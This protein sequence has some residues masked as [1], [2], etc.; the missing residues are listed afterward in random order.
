MD[1]TD[2]RDI[3]PV[4]P[5]PILDPLLGP[6]GVVGA[7][8][9][10]VVSTLTALLILIKPEG[11]KSSPAFLYAAMVLVGVLIS[12]ARADWSTLVYA[13][14]ILPAFIGIRWLYR[15]LTRTQVP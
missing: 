13:V 3:G 5:A 7:G 12:V 2:W 4:Y 8:A 14:L 9:V 15:K 1:G 6:L 11:E 10:L